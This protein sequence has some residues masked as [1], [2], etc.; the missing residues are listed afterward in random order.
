MKRKNIV[1]VMSDEQTWNT[2]SLYGNKTLRTSH[3][4]LLAQDGV[5]FDHCYTAYPLCCPARSTLWTGLLPHNHHV[6]GNWRHIR[7]ELRDQGLI[8]PFRDAGY[9]TVYCGKWHVP[10]TTPERYG[11]NDAVAIPA[12]VKGQD[13]GRYITEYRE[14]AIAQG[15]PLVEGMMENL[16][17][18]D[19]AQMKVRGKAPC[20]TS[21]I[22]LEHYLETWQTGKFLEAL[23]RRPDDQ[24]FFAVVSYN[25]P[26]FPLIVPE[27]YDKLVDPDSV[28][29]PPNFHGTLDGKPE[30]LRNL[31]YY[32]QME[33]LPEAEWRRFIAHY[34]GFCSLI[35]DQLGRIVQYLK[36]QGEYEDTIVVFTS[37]HGDMMGAHRLIE[38]GLYLHYDEALRVPLIM[39]HAG[40]SGERSDGFV[41]LHDLL[42]TLA[43][44]TDTPMP[45]PQDAKSFAGLLRQ[46]CDASSERE[47]VLSETF[48]LRGGMNGSGDDMPPEQFRKEDGDVHLS[49]RS[50]TFRYTF[51]YHGPDE[52]YDKAADPHEMTNVAEDPAYAGPLADMRRKLVQELRDSSLFMT[53]LVEDRLAKK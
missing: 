20:G 43:E 31:H 25:A 41:M 8:R 24:P 49:L 52:L 7:E 51:H 21:E 6:T 15:Y 50:K 38:K 33:G 16:T 9:H 19:M 12:V 45:M 4:D 3:A 36:E 44:C 32:K 47:A 23:E 14:Y 13:R 17:E 22:R 35:D 53:K 46:P 26:H 27:P 42:P 10:G 29:L 40:T 18:R 2:L 37:D 34:L 1:I 30:E 39:A 48:R 5:A 11:V 28:E